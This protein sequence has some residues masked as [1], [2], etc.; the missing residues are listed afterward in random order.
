MP[1]SEPATPVTYAA[2]LGNHPAISLAELRSAVPDLAVR[3]MIGQ[4]IAI[5][6]TTQKLDNGDL[7]N[8]GGIFLLAR[9]IP[10]KHQMNQVPQLLHAEVANVKGK[11][12]FSL[13][14]HGVG[15]N[16][17]HKMYR[18]VKT[19][20]KKQ[21]LPVRYVGNEHK[22][23]VSA[24]LHDEG[25]ITGKEGCE[26]VLLGD[27]DGDYLWVGRT[28]ATQDPDAYT[29]RDMEKPVRDTRVGLLPPKLAQ[30]MLNLGYWVAREAKP[31]IKK[32][33]TVLDPFC[34]TGVIP[35]EALIREWPVLASDA[36]QKAVTGCETNLDWIRKERKILKKDVTS[37]TWKQDATKAFDLKHLP[38]VIVTETSLGPALS[39]RPNTKD[40]A[41]FRAECDAL[42]TAFLKNVAATLPGVPVVATFPVWYIKTGP[43]FL[44]KTWKSLEDIGFEAVLPPGAPSDIPGRTS[45][46]YRRPDQFVGREI[47]ILKPVKRS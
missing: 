23:P 30:I 29:R 34:G 46:I 26:I 28:I 33:I 43:V 3:R 5:F 12:T 36:S 18:D 44:E 17:I 7:Q 13:R 11:V 22:P 19:Y 20:L 10:G 25:L 24:Q 31:S 47:V 40:A 4:T 8:W 21:G 14:A 9:E 41:K 2:F 16:I 35:M 42:E 39:D 6:S 1:K 15:R 32:T 38:D 45:L 27:D 37:E